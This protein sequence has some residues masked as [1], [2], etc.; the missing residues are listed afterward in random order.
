MYVF[1]VLVYLN[2]V[3][4]YKLLKCLQGV[5]ISQHCLLEREREKKMQSFPVSVLWL[6]SFPHKKMVID[7]PS[8]VTGTPSFF[9][10]VI[11]SSVYKYRSLPFFPYLL[12]QT[13]KPHN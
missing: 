12:K 4:S 13:N 2:E 7:I 11:P 6:S 8:F 3:T 1:A 10:E 5:S 9:A